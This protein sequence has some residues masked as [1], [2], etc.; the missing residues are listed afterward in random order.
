MAAAFNTTPRGRYAA[1]LSR[2][3]T[4][5]L[6]VRDKCARS[7]GDSSFGTGRSLHADSG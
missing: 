2:R 7:Q 1:T 4:R 5:A 6:A 3:H